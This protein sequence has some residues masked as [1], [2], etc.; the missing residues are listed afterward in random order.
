MLLDPVNFQSA[1]TL[2]VGCP[3]LKDWWTVLTLSCLGFPPACQLF[4]P[5]CE[6]PQHWPASECCS[7]FISHSTFT[8]SNLI[9]SHNFRHHSVYNFQIGIFHSVHIELPALE[10]GMSK[11]RAPQLT[12]SPREPSSI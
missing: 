10:T 11:T 3:H 12:L 1:F 7:C 6:L 4:H 2:S 5:L 8:L 9:H